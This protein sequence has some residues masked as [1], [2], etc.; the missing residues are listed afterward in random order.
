MAI[1]EVP[2]AGREFVKDLETLDRLNRSRL[3]SRYCWR[4]CQAD[5]NGNAHAFSRR[6]L[7]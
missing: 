4:E 2:S 3:E 7:I 5:E 6:N 1:L